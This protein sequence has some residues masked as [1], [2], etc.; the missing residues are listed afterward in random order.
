MKLG[1]LDATLGKGYVVVILKGTL[2]K[3]NKSTLK[4]VKQASQ[5]L[6]W[7]MNQKIGFRKLAYNNFPNSHENLKL[8]L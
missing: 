2:H 1:S 8:E 5:Q 4:S 6:T 7:K 3:M